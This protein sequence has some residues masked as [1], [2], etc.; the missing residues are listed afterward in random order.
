MQRQVPRPSLNQATK[1]VEIPQTQYIDKVA[2][3]I[4]QSP[5]RRHGRRH[6]CCVEATGSSNPDGGQSADQPGDQE[7]RD[8]ADTVHRPGCCRAY[9]D[10]AT[11]RI[12]TVA[13]T[14]E[15]PPAPFIGRIMDVPVFMQRQVPQIQTVAKTVE[16]P[17][18]PFIGRIADVP[19]ISE[20]QA[21]Q[22]PASGEAAT[23]PSGS[24]GVGECG[25]PAGVF[26]RRSS[27]GQW[28]CCP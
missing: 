5:S 14:V 23:G 26:R 19:G 28:W 21:C 12:Q 1:H 3:T 2:V 18:V 15:V 16:V 10:A 20:I 22:N 11:G 4:P 17:P 7:R 24:N 8:S 6:A 25:S 9:C 27:S 13:K